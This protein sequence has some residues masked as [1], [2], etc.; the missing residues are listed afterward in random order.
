MQKALYPVVVDGGSIEVDNF[1]Y[2]GSCIA[3]DS[4]VQEEVSLCISETSKALEAY[5]SQ[6]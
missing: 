2:L 4:D 3:A 5:I 6:S 1:I